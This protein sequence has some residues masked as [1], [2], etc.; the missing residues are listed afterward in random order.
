MTSFNFLDN[1]FISII[2]Y[3]FFKSSPWIKLFSIAN[4]LILISLELY[5]LDEIVLN[6]LG[7]DKTL[8]SS[9]AI[10]VFPT[11]GVPV[12]KII[13]FIVLSPFIALIVAIF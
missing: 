1:L 7:L 9:L 8:F 6:S 10:V 4:S 2:L 3:P 12:I 11:P 13:L 5:F